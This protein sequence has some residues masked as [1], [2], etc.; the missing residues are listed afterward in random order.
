M[1]GVGIIFKEGFGRVGKF[2]TF[3]WNGV[4]IVVIDELFCDLSSWVEF[5]ISDDIMGDL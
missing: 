4:D 1:M 2:N 3:G 5:V